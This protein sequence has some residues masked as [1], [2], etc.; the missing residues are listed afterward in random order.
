MGKAPDFGETVAKRQE[1]TRRDK[2]RQEAIGS[3]RSKDRV[4]PDVAGSTRLDSM[5]KHSII[6]EKLVSTFQKT[7]HKRPIDS[8]LETNDRR[9]RTVGYHH[10][11]LAAKDMQAIH[12]FYEEVMQFELVKVE[13]GPSP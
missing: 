6:T 12:H 11:A 9:G 7:E 8:E 10:L 1:A 2:K 13:V 4:R 5:A 3:D